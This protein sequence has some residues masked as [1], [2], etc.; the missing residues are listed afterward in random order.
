[1]IRF[2]PLLLPALVACVDFDAEMAASASGQRAPATLVEYGMVSFLNDASTTVDLLDKQV[3]LNA[4]TARNLI[5]HR[6]GPD[7]VFGTDDDDLFD[8]I[9]EIDAVSWV[10]PSALAALEAYVDANG[11][12]PSA[13]DVLGVF[14]GVS[15]TFGEAAATLDLVNMAYAEV[16]DDQVPLDVRAVNSI[17]DARPIAE[18]GELADL[19]F[20]GGTALTRLKSF[21]N[22]ID[23]APIDETPVEPW[24][25]DFTHDEELELP[26]GDYAGVQSGVHP[27]QVPAEATVVTF[28]MDVLHDDPS[29]V[30]VELTAPDGT[31]FVIEGLDADT[32]FVAQTLDY[33]GPI[34]ALWTLVVR[35]IVVGIEGSQYGWNLHVETP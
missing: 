34:E 7:G 4:R 12:V 11:W 29:Q 5:A 33:N 22:P 14:D 25:D 9:D 8:S 19:Y 3:P 28:S 15:F 2:A 6:D 13:D 32:S 20:V 26:D 31:L 18:M 30:E 1:M 24:S 10:G 17:V 21:A 27:R 16:L 35:D 23:Q